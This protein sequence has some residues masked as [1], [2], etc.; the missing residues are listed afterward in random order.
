[1]P[2]DLVRVGMPASLTGQFSGQGAQALAGTE[3]WVRDC[4]AAGGL[5]VSAHGAK[6]P[7]Q[8]VHYDDQSKASAARQVTERLIVQDRVDPLLGPYSSVLTLAM[9]PVA[10]EHR[11]VL[12]NHGGASDQ[13][14]QQGHRWAVGVLTPASGYLLGVIDLMR[15]RDPGARKLA[16]LYSARGTFPKAVASGVEK[17]ASERGLEIVYS[18]AYQAPVDDYSPWLEEIEGSGPDLF[19]G[20]GR[21]QEDLRLARQ[22]AQRKVKLK[23]AVV[24]AAGIARFREELG[25][26]A[27]GFMGPSPWE[28]G[29][30]YLPD[31]GP[32]ARELAQRH[33]F[34]GA[35]GAD[36]AMAQAYAAGLV[37]QRCVEEA[38]TLDSAALREVAG[39]LDF[40]TFY[41]RFKIDQVSGRQ[42]G[43][44]VVTVQWQGGHKVVVWPSE[45]R[46]GEMLYPF[47]PLG[48]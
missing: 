36:Y 37:A 7:L 13:I 34:F 28:P 22:V 46:Q 20:V 32:P 3:A 19:I 41:G 17:Y 45:V 27:E 40:T 47:E 5:Y 42:I 12:W 39:R 10:E 25:S 24:V 15:E 31:Y 38:G 18:A 16:L 11:R 2:E 29:V 30:D 23:A 8:L 6:L 33:S 14:H 21:I 4:N 9:A 1:M 43:R 26:A 48:G 35:D 44:S